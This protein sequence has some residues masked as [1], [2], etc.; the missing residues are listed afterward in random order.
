MMASRFKIL[1]LHHY[2]SHAYSMLSLV[3]I[4]NIQEESLFAHAPV[5]E[6]QDTFGQDIQ[7]EPHIWEHDEAGQ[8]TDNDN[9][10][11]LTH[12]VHHP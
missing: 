1:Q 3:Q 10:I 9:C 8:F 11:A 2:E 7:V 6:H 12:L 4:C 5:V